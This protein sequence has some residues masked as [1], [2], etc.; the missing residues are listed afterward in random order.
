M[1]NKRNRFFIFLP[2]FTI[3]FYG[4]IIAL[5]FLMRIFFNELPNAFQITMDVAA[6]IVLDLLILVVVVEII[7]KFFDKKADII[8]LF[9]A[10]ACVGI[11]VLSPDFLEVIDHFS[12]LLLSESFIELY[13]Y[14]RKLMTCLALILLIEH[15]EKDFSYPLE[16]KY[17]YPIYIV[18]IVLALASYF[19]IASYIMF[20]V[21]L[22]FF[23]LLSLF[24]LFRKKPFT[25][26]FYVET[27]IYIC[28][29]G[30]IMMEIPHYI[31]Q[32]SYLYTGLTSVLLFTI[33]ISFFLIYLYF[34]IR[35]TKES[36]LKEGIEK[37]L[38]E[39]QASALENQ[40][41]PHFIF[42][43]LQLIKAI[44]RE[45]N[46][47]GEKALD[48]IAAY[49][50][51]YTDAGK[52]ILVPLEKELEM[53]ENFVSVINLK[54][55]RHMNV[56]YDIDVYDFE[57]P[58]FGLQPYVENVALYSGIS[59]KEDGQLIISSYEDEENYFIEVKD[60]GIGFDITNIKTTSYGIT[61]SVERYKLSLNA[62]TKIDSEINVGT[63]IK[64]RIP[65]K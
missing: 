31:F 5:G 30:I 8:T 62:Y 44:Y 20:T 6:G 38:E 39:L 25:F 19:H 27:I 13:N 11:F 33:C 60:N 57:V 63:T 61:N 64:I 40:M 49:M 12:P 15:M 51:N 50:R 47:K 29:L 23:L 26:N 28:L 18:L 17:K 48:I 21:Y 55:E 3:L 42:N 59:S 53:I 22:L 1:K 46:E 45:D 54:S 35:Q 65:K 10:L 2:I 52:N 4:V 7:A 56:I 9:L 58:Y 32:L 41:S 14:F 36:Y 24:Y 37:R 43:S 16:K 34:I